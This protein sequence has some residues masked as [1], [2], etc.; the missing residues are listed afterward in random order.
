MFYFY[1]I[2]GSMLNFKHVVYM[3]RCAHIYVHIVIVST[4]KEQTVKDGWVD[5]SSTSH[6]KLELL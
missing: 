2:F 6:L 5:L 3:Y 1:L 4:V